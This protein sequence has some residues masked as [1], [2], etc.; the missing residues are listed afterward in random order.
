MYS[1]RGRCVNVRKPV[2]KESTKWN[3]MD[4]VAAK[5]GEPVAVIVFI[6]IKNDSEVRRVKARQGKL[7]F[8]N[9]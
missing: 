4:S 3:I 7:Y 5:M 2:W 9:L 6:K 8:C 1:L